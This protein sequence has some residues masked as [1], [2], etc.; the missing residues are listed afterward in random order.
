[1]AMCSNSTNE[2]IRWTSAYLINDKIRPKNLSILCDSVVDKITF[3]NNYNK[4]E[5][6]ESFSAKSVLLQDIDGNKFE[7]YLEDSDSD[8][9][10][11]DVV[12]CNGAFGATSVLQRSGVGP[13][14]TLKKVTIY[15]Y[16][17]TYL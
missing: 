16:L 12:L 8:S 5:E 11:G 9:D 4:T 3:Q 10:G 15:L 1:M 13:K 6:Y 2:E 17:Y 14:N 7:V